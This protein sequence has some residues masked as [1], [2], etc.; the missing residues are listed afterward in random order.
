MQFRTLSS[1]LLLALPLM[2]AA[3]PGRYDSTYTL[4]ARD[5]EYYAERALEARTALLEATI[6][7]EVQRRVD[8]A[9]DERDA[10]PVSDPEP[11][12]AA[13]PEP[14]PQPEPEPEVQK[15]E[16]NNRMWR[17]RGGTWGRRLTR[18]L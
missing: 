10:T 13:D 18:D 8:Q 3:M 1:I 2:T 5:A 15:R 9:L 6:E 14:A 11:E 16:E 17:R 4:R 7:N 12:P